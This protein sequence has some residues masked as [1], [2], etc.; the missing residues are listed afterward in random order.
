MMGHDNG[1]KKNV[2]M[3]VELGHYGIQLKKLY[4]GNNN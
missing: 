4:W 1:R 2:H 3:Y